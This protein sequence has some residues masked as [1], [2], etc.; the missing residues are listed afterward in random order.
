M[1][2]DEFL[3]N[4]GFKVNH[5]FLVHYGAGRDAFEKK[6]LNYT[7]PGEIENYEITFVQHLQDYDFYTSEKLVSN[8]LFNVK[9]RIRRSA[10]DDFIIKCVFF[11]ENE[12]PSPF[13]NEVLIVNFRY[14]SIEAYQTK[15]FNDYNYFNSRERTLKRV[16]NN[17]MTGSSW[18]FNKFLYVN[19]KILDSVS[20]IF[21]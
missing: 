16:I 1:R 7:H 8:F 18:H 5:D 14:S 4:H 17:A 2:C 6:P 3:L 15:S 11:L 10:E 12:Q 20:H 19:V 13:E 9:Y 21:W